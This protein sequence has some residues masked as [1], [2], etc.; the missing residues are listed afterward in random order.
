MATATA[1]INGI[2]IQYDMSGAGPPVLFLNGHG[3]R[4]AHWDRQRRALQ[5][6]YRVITFD[7]RAAPSGRVPAEPVYPVPQMADDAVAL[8]DHLGIERA[9]L[10]GPST[11]SLIA[12]EIALRHAERV[13]SLT[14]ASAWPHPGPLDQITQP[15]LVVAAAEDTLPPPRVSLELA[16]ALPNARFE[17]MPGGP[18]FIAEYSDRFNEALLGFLDWLGAASA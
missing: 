8:L 12:Q 15:T 18:R 6:R 4:A 9:H 13:R 11:G 5:P 2:G 17:W 7:D 14:L 3:A 10:V 1:K 16:R